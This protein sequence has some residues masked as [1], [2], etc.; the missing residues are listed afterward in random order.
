MEENLDIPK[1]LRTCI[2]LLEYS[3]EKTISARTIQSAFRIVYSDD[4]E[5]LKQGIMAGT[6]YVTEYVYNTDTKIN[7]FN[8]YKNVLRNFMQNDIRVLTTQEYRLGSNSIPY[9]CG[10]ADTLNNRVQQFN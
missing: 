6:K 9:L 1:L 10:I 7:T 4:N 3:R 2:V 8:H 5:I